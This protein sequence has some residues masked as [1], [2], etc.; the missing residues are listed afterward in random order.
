[1][2]A[3]AVS[4]LLWSL[5]P[6]AHPPATGRPTERDEAEREGTV[7]RRVTAALIICLVVA[8]FTAACLEEL[9][10]PQTLCP[11]G[12][13][14]C[15]SPSV[16]QTVNGG[17]CCTV[18]NVSTGALVPNAALGYLCAFGSSRTPAGCFASLE[19]ARFACPNA[20]SIVR[21]TQE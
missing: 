11:T 19:Q 3:Y 17:T 15:G 4:C 10:G 14:Y 6:T 20:P 13:L 1:M 9:T 8:G 18:V 16:P 21:C 2:S 12:L 7:I 5:L